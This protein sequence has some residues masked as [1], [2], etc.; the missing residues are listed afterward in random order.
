MNVSCDTI[1]TRYGAESDLS[2]AAGHHLNQRPNCSVAWNRLDLD[3]R[4]ISLL[5]GRLP[6]PILLRDTH[7]ERIR[8]KMRSRRAAQRGTGVTGSDLQ[9]PVLDGYCTLIVPWIGEISGIQA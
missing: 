9:S 5:H 7:I 4:D 1:V 8:K 2:V 6:H 3:L